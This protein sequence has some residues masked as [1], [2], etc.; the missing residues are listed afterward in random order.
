MFRGTTGKEVG[1][2]VLFLTDDAAVAATYVKSGGQVM[3]Y[4]MSQFSLKALQATSEL[5]LKTGI[6]GMEGKVSTEFMF[7]GKELIEAVNSLAT[8]LK[9]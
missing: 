7:K 8:P 1:S 2:T 9:K 4:E 6:H 5:E 3:Q